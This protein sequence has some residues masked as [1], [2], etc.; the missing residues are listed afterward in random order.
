MNLRLARPPSR[1]SGRRRSD[2]PSLSAPEQLEL[3]RRLLRVTPDVCLDPFVADH[4]D[5]VLE[6]HP[7][8]RDGSLLLEIGRTAHHFGG[9]AALVSKVGE[10]C[11]RLGLLAAIGVDDTPEAARVRARA[12]R[13]RE[14]G[15]LAP[16]AAL[17]WRAL[18]PPPPIADTL[19][20]LGV[21]TIG[22]LLYLPRAGLATRTS[23]AFVQQLQR[24]LGELEEPLER[25]APP[26]RF[27]QTIELAGAATHAGPLLAAARELFERAERE[28]EGRGE[29]LVSA[30]V[31]FVPLDRHRE[32]APPQLAIELA[33][34]EPTRSARLLVRLLEHRLERERLAAPIELVE[35]VFDHTLELRA[36]QEPLFAEG[37][38]GSAAD[39]ALD[40]DLQHEIAVLRDRLAVRLG[41]D[42]VLTAE[43][44]ADHR[45]EVAFRWKE[46]GPARVAEAGR[47]ARAAAGAQGRSA[48]ADEARGLPDPPIA[49]APA[50]GARPLELLPWPEPIRVEADAD[51]RPH[52]LR[53]EG[54]SCS[55]RPIRGPER[56]AS[57]WW[58]GHDVERAYF[59]VEAE[60]GSHLWLFR[61][62]KTG[63]WYLHGAFS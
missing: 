52:E 22:D 51:Q 49:A 26:Y 43:L 32:G 58:D 6:A 5:E 44:L 40:R 14:S 42:R 61:D 57:G 47:G 18:A 50:A 39:P 7:G 27:D 63:A 36:A 54:R 2:P 1:Q 21:R 48:N 20:F 60:D 28:L 46:H 34:S 15:E 53:E 19:G 33:P 55:L 10:R 29:A 3:A 59:E 24:M 25:I 12:S 8:S 30:I 35:L 45:P 16:L 17:P 4:G 56:V 23:I 31:K 37:S 9:E 11:R 13:L 41:V 62:L 38:G